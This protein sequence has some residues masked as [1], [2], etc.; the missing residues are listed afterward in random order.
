MEGSE[1]RQNGSITISESV[2]RTNPQDF[3]RKSLREHQVVVRDESGDTTMILGPSGRDL[4]PEEAAPDEQ[5]VPE[6]GP[7]IDAEDP[8]LYSSWLQ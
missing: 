1:H 7:N 2:F 3:I 8:Q 4:F 6:S 5:G